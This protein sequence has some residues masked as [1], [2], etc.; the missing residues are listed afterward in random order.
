MNNILL[1]VA[2]LMALITLYVAIRTIIDTRRRYYSNLDSSQRTVR[3][4]ARRVLY[5]RKDGTY[6][7]RVKYIDSEGEEHSATVA[8]S[9]DQVNRIFSLVQ[10][11]Y[12]Q[13]QRR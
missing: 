12:N 8:L 4:V 5:Q 9:D 7:Y 2:I 13:A 6:F 10:D 3:D 11:E 1:A